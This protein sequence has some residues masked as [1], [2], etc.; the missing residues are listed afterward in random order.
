[1]FFHPGTTSTEHSDYHISALEQF[2]GDILHSI[3]NLPSRSDDI[4]HS[5]VSHIHMFAIFFV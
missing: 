5:G 2:L 1:V 4:F 3:A